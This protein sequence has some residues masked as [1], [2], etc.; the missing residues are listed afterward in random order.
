MRWV[1]GKQQIVVPFFLIKFAKWC[2]L[3]GEFSPLTFGVNIDKLV[4]IPVI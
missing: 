1:S 3:M 2:L 4:V